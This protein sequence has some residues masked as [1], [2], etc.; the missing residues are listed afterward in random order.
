MPRLVLLSL[1]AFAAC[2]TI[3]PR[4]TD[5]FGEVVVDLDYPVDDI[6]RAYALGARFQLSTTQSSRLESSDLG[7]LSIERVNGR[8]YDAVAASEGTSVLRFRSDG[9]QGSSRVDVLRATSL[10]VDAVGVI[11]GSVARLPIVG[12]NGDVLLGVRGQTA[13]TTGSAS[14]WTP[15]RGGDEAWATVAESGTLE[16]DVALETGA[17]SDVFTISLPVVDSTDVAMIMIE[18]MYVNELEARAFTAEGERVLGGTFRWTLE[19]E[20]IVLDGEVPSDRLMGSGDS[21]LSRLCAELGERRAC[22]DTYYR[23]FDGI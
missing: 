20:D 1:L 15:E 4:L 13:V 12:R 14:A 23:D 2:Q 11:A 8:L 18:R 3:L 9:S 22:I 5:S 10:D 21:D 17:G 7:V 6:E 16:V 19:G